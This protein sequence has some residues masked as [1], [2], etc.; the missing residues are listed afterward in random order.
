MSV[1]NLVDYIYIFFIFSVAGWLIEVTLKS[2]QFK[3]FTNRGF[4]VGPYCPIYGLGA[5][6]IV[7]TNNYLGTY[8]SSA[9]LIFLS[10]VF[11][12]GLVEYLVSYFLEKNYHARWWDYSY[13][14]MNLNGRIWIGNLILFGLGGLLIVRV[15]NPIFMDLFYKLDFSV[16]KYLVI[17]I[18]IL[19]LADYIVSYFVMKL[20]K[21]NVEQSQADNT[22]DIKNEIK[23][24]ATN[25]NIL[26]NRFIDAYPEVKYRTDRIKKRLKDLELETKRLREEIERELAEQ[27]EALKEDIK[28]LSLIKNDLIDSQERLIELLENDLADKDQIKKLKAEIKDQ[29]ELLEKKKKL[30]KIDKIEN[31]KIL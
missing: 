15:F 27:K 5:F 10:S 9:A 20:V 14:P 26:Y 29:K 31:L 28:P 11:I 24:L 8:D 4:L 2:I 25:K 6:L 17:V 30:L 1:K 3:K 22:E 18:S 19:M 13:K 23:L 21:V 12:C 16:R 7:L